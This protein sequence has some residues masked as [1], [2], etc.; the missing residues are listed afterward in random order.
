M[1]LQ[2]VSSS[3]SL[4]STIT[5]EDKKPQNCHSNRNRV[6]SC[7]SFDLTRNVEY[8]ATTVDADERSFVWYTRS[9]YNEMKQE[10]IDLGRQFQKYDKSISD[11][12]SF[13]VMLRKAFRAC[14]E[15]TE[16]P[17]SCLL[18]REDEKVLRRWLSKGS[19]RGLEK[20]S[21]LSIFADKNARRKRIVAAVLEAQD[22]S[23]DMD[24]LQ[25]AEYIRD[26]A[27]V[28]SRTSRHFAWRLA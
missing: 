28:I 27:M 23:Q 6:A 25:R 7:V 16:D 2:P 4:S 22:K 14:N 24:E 21:V 19:R 18:E 11:P 26:Q 17:I 9:E 8:I 10:Y 13:K 1:M 15:A 5:V 12:Q 20:I 3:N